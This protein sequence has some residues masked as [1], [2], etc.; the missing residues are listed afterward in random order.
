MR[1]QPPSPEPYRT[2]GSVQGPPRRASD[3]P[4]RACAVGPRGSAGRGGVAG[5]DSRVTFQDTERSMTVSR[6]ARRGFFAFAAALATF[7]RVPPLEA[8]GGSVTGFDH[9]ALPMQNTEAMIAF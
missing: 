3:P 1:F 5:V 7:G 8:Q 6:S 4:C 9:V 2:S